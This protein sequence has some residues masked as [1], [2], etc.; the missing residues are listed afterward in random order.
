MRAEKV[1]RGKATIDHGEPKG[2]ERWR[3]KRKDV[4]GFLAYAAGGPSIGIIIKDLGA[5][6]VAAAAAAAGGRSCR[7]T[8]DVGLVP[9]RP[10]SRVGAPNEGRGEDTAREEELRVR[11]RGLAII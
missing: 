3:G 6:G 2:R 4:S 11:A 7:C 10:A 9:P 5:G 8:S 1:L